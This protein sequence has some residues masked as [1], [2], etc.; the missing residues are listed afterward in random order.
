M[1][2][3]RRRRNERHD[4]E[5][6]LAAIVAPQVD[7]G[8]C[9]DVAHRRLGMAYAEKQMFDLAEVEFRKALAISEFDSETM[10]AMAYAYAM[11]GR[12]DDSRVVLDRM[13]EL[14]IEMYVSPYSLARVYIGLDE[15]DRAFE[16]LERTY[17]ERHGILTY[18]KVEPVFDRVRSDPRFESLLSRLNI[19]SSSSKN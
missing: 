2:V 16:C 12:K 3:D 14:S 17:L 18:L 11:A 4:A 19:N 7:L 5:R 1:T 10:S 13:N 9:G 15:L 8:P 6:R